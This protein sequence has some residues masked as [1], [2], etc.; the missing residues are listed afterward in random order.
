MSNSYFDFKQF[1]V[2]HDLCAMKVGTDGVLLGAWAHGSERV[3]DVGTGSGLI[4]LFMA[5]RYPE[6]RI[7]AIDIDWDAYRQTLMN[8]MASPFNSRITVK[9]VD[10]QH[11]LDGL[12]GS[13][14]CN[15][16]FFKNSLHCP[17][18]KRTLARHDT[19]L[20]A[21][22]LMHHASRLLSLGGELSIIIPAELRRL[23][24]S[25]A[26]FAGLAPSRA[27][28]IK[29]TRYK[30]VSRCLLAYLKGR[31]VAVDERQVCLLDEDGKSSEWYKSLTEDFYLNNL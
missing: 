5:Q 30:A 26:L 7:T 15:P 16:P 25:E 18:D 17:D 12:F 28:L 3:L 29:T 20:S 31:H 6:A 21:T 22:D 27:Y 2:Y 9:H 10:F 23:Y 11:L 8:K 1:R 24:D 13:I 14:V 4:A 19:A